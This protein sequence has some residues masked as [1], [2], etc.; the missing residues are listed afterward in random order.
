MPRDLRDRVIVITGA[1][2]GIGRA[3]A[4]ACARAGMDVVLNARR[5]DRLDEVALAYFGTA[6]PDSAGIRHRELAPGEPQEGWVA[7]SRTRLK[8][9]P[10]Y[11]WLEEYEPDRVV[12]TSIELYRIAVEQ[13]GWV[14]S[15]VPEDRLTV[16]LYELALKSAPIEDVFSELP[17]SFVT[18]RAV[19]FCKQIGIASV[20]V[21]ATYSAGKES[22]VE[23]HLVRLL[24]SIRPV[25]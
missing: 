7:I 6:S 10:G 3:T 19:L 21:H 22:T 4:L 14:L 17:D 12:G 11:E 18:R 1:S 20:V 13:N 9:E 23:P 25:W 15:M 2:S 16:G 24:R 5:A 8:M